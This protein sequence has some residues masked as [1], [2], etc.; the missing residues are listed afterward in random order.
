VYLVAGLLFGALANSAATQQTRVVWR[1][2]A[3][4]VSA[5]A[6]IAHICYEQ[7]RVRT[8]VGTTALHVASAVALGAF[9]LALSATVHA[10]TTQQRFP[11][12][13]LVLWPIATGIPA[14]L[15]AFAAAF[16]LSRSRQ[17]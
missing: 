9:G 4:A 5:M 11:G 10:H 8:S 12:L 17:A 15:V 7:L 14:F 1:L 16:L 13:M 3:W 6:F 2:A